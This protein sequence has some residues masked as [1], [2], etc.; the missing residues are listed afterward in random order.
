MEDSGHYRGYG[1][2]YLDLV[3]ELDFELNSVGVFLSFLHQAHL[4]NEDSSFAEGKLALLD[5]RIFLPPSIVIDLNDPTK[6]TAI[7]IANQPL[8]LTGCGRNARTG[9]CGASPAGLCV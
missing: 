2:P 6:E 1:K 8:A 9:L 5:V 4:M 7:C 3:F